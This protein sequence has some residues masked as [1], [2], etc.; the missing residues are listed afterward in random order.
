MSGDRGQ[1]PRRRCRIT[2]YNVC[3]TKLL[4]KLVRRH[5]HVFGD[6]PVDGAEAA[7]RNWERMKL[8]EHAAAD[9]A[10]QC[11]DENRLKHKAAQFG[12]SLVYS[13]I[14]GTAKRIFSGGLV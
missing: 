5:P 8:Q 6:T 14:D 12:M 2:S 3:Y 4:R 1:A 10:R 13:R 9:A 7:Y 11:F